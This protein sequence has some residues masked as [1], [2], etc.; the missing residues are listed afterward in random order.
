MSVRPK[1][2]D[3]VRREFAEAGVSISAWAR[4]NGFDR[5][6]VS[7]LLRPTSRLRG[8]HG[9]A[10]RCAIALGLKV[11]HVVDVKRFKPAPPKVT[12]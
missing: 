1:T 9:E 10:H 2:T 7:A 11:G 6:M 3:Q 12:A 4:A 5:S 8:H